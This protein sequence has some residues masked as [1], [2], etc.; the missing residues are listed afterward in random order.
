MRRRKRSRDIVRVRVPDAQSSF[1]EIDGVPWLNLLWNYGDALD[2]PWRE[3]RKLL[4]SSNGDVIIVRRL[5]GA[6]RKLF[7]SYREIY[8]EAHARLIFKDEMRWQQP[9]RRSGGRR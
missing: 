1:I 5:L 3:L 4:A 8:R 9:R 2:V 6:D 7:E